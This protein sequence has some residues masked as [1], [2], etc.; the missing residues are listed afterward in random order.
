MRRKVGTVA[1]LWRYPVKSMRG[2]RVG[3]LRVTER[4]AAGDRLYAMR[5][6][7]YGK[8]MSARLFA[9]MLQLRAACEN[10]P[11]GGAPARV[12]IELPGGTT[13]YAGEPRTDEI[14]STLFGFAVRLERP[15]DAPLAMEEIDAI[16]EGRA[17]LPPR[18]LYDEDVLHLLASGTL[19]HLRRLRH[20]DS[21]FD[22]RRFRPNIYVDTGTDTDGSLEA[23][24]FVEDRWLGGELEIGADRAR[25]VGMRP[26]AALRDDHP[27]AGRTSPRPR[28]PAHRHAASWRLRRNFR[29]GRRARAHPRRRPGVAGYGVIAWS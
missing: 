13:A 27:S 20:G 2:E 5:E 17:F 19:A 11:A 1:Q 10:E 28:D 25:I 26:A 18:D 4:G 29:L 3:E 21:D 8:I 23:S 16:R 9:V 15:R 24:G 7:K 12:R 22:V 6:L 14:L